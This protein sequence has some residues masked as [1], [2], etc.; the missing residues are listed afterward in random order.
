MNKPSGYTLQGRLP[1]WA[2]P[3]IALAKAGFPLLSLTQNTLVDYEK[4]A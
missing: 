3:A 4:M 1:M 2:S